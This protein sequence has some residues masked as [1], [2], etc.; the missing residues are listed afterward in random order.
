MMVDLEKMIPSQFHQYTDWDHF[1]KVQGNCPT[2][3]IVNM[4]FKN[5]T[6]LATMIGLLK[7]VKEELKNV[8]QDS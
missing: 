4:W 8:L 3:T 6:S 5:E 1:R 2:K 7:V